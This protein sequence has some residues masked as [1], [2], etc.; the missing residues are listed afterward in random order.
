MFAFLGIVHR[1]QTHHSHVRADGHHD[2]SMVHRVALTIRR[3]EGH[4]IL[5]DT[6]GLKVGGRNPGEPLFIGVKGLELQAT[7]E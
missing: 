7:G 1:F 4:Q 5:Q 6:D 2:I 3:M